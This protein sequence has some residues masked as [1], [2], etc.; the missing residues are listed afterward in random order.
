MNQ[1][2]AIL[3][4]G[5]VCISS[6][7]AASGAV[8]LRPLENLP[9]KTFVGT[10]GEKIIVQYLAPKES[11]QVLIKFIGFDDGDWNNKVVLHTKSATGEGELYHE[12]FKTSEM[13][14]P[15]VVMSGI[16]NPIIKVRPKGCRKDT[17]VKYSESDSTGIHPYELI[18]AYSPAKR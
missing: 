7:A 3:Y 16:Q 10:T 8:D 1:F 4:L 6:F 11:K 12:D 15:T 13:T 14:Y 18:R 17:V 9:A 5:L 2:L